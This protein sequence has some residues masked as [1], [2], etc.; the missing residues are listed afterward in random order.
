MGRRRPRQGPLPV[1]SRLPGCEPSRPRCQ[2]QRS[3]QGRGCK[4]RA[5]RRNSF[6]QEV[7]LTCAR[8]RIFGGWYADGACGDSAVT[9]GE[10]QAPAS[11]AGLNQADMGCGSDRGKGM[12]AGG[13]GVPL[14]ATL[15]PSGGVEAGSGGLRLALLG[16]SAKRSRLLPEVFDDCSSVSR[17]LCVVVSFE[18][19]CPR[20]RFSRTILRRT[21]QNF[22]FLFTLPPP[23]S[24]AFWP[25]GFHQTARELQTRT[26]EGPDLQKH[27]QNSTRRPPRER[28]KSENGG[29][30]GKKKREILGPHSSGPPPLCS[31]PFGPGSPH[32]SGPPPTWAT[33]PF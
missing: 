12:M 31:S 8:I 16:A 25:P 22:V 18:Y 32:P 24:L 15:G 10:V 30:R 4:K 33:A 17:R 7:G 9:G 21:A 26:F 29:G 13:G 5:H 20:P 6:G 14:A 28:R 11:G 3:K 23:F 1:A 19:W 2:Q 27:H